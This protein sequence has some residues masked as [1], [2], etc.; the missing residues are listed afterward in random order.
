MATIVTFDPVALIIEEVDAGG[1]A[2]NDLSVLEVYSEWKDA[3]LAD[4]TRLAWPPAFRVVGGDP[5]SGAQSLGSTFFLSNGWRIR[6]AEYSHR[7]VL[8]GNLFTDPAGDSPFVPTLGAYT[9]VVETATSNLI[10][11]ITVGGVDQATVQAALTAQGYTA[12]RAP[13]IDLLDSAATSAELAAAAAA[14]S[15]EVAAVP[16]ATTMATVAALVGQGLTAGQ[17]TMLLEVYEL[18]GLDPAKPLVVDHTAYRRVPADGS[19]INQTVA[20]A[21]D[22]VTVTRT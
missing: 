18:L 14:T 2:T 17:A 20:T 22:V 16:A 19:S 21:G 11:T 1:V 15:A 3:L 8:H 10:D 12:I 6:P 5:V 7:L 4:P 13:K 9:V